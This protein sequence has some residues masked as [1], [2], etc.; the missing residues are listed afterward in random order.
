MNG[1][2]S[3]LCLVL[4]SL[5]LAAR[6]QRRPSLSLLIRDNKLQ[7]ADLADI[8]I[9]AACCGRG[10]GLSPLQHASKVG[11]RP[12]TVQM[13][14]DASA[15]THAA[16]STGTTALMFAAREGSTEALLVLLAAFK[17]ESGGS[18]GSG[19]GSGASSVDH[20]LAELERT[21]EH[22]NTALHLAALGGK[23]A[24]ARVLIEAGGDRT[25]AWMLRKNSHGNTAL[26]YAAHKCDLG[27]TLTDML[28]AVPAVA[29]AV[30]EPANNG[31]TALM[32]AANN[33][34]VQC[35]ASLLKAGANPHAGSGT[36][37]SALSLATSKG[38]AKV[39]ELLEQH[40]GVGGDEL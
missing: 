13:I 34:R 9:D 17:R 1:R 29:A 5:S 25:A 23:V 20:V 27:A 7:P 4:V 36:G 35:V 40:G 26:Q 12:A 24:S 15:N 38:H 19:S 33:N 6:P 32:L 28:L 30:D 31:R 2:A 18:G 14:I 39:M 3:A 8:F 11:A 21:D 37:D 22:L 16:H 10:N